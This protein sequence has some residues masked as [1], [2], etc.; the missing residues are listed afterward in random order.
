MKDK[1]NEIKFSK[2]LTDKQVAVIL[3]VSQMKLRQD[4]HNNVGPPYRRYGAGTIRYDEAEL[5]EW[6]ERQKVKSIE[7]HNLLIKLREINANLRNNT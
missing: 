2:Q 7:D 5:F 6:M 3:N 4:R 1:D